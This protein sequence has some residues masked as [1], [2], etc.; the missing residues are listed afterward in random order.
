[1]GPRL[2]HLG[3]HG[4]HHAAALGITQWR[5]FALVIV[6]DRCR[7]LFWSFGIIFQLILTALNQSDMQARGCVSQMLR[8]GPSKDQPPPAAARYQLSVPRLEKLQPPVCGGGPV[9]P[10]L[11]YY[12]YYYRLH[13]AATTGHRGGY[14][15][16]LQRVYGGWWWYRSDAGRGASHAGTSPVTR[17]NA[18]VCH[19]FLTKLHRDKKGWTSTI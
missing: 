17:D 11:R 9:P 10:Q 4:V 19:H 8:P 13:T 12:S 15:R 18:E 16:S 5:E 14:C 3:V 1:M 2:H 6:I 7:C